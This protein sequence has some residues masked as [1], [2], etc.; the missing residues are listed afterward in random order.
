VP[1]QGHPKEQ[2]A[3]YLRARL[4]P[5]SLLRDFDGDVYAGRPYVVLIGIKDGPSEDEAM[6]EVHGPAFRAEIEADPEIAPM[7]DRVRALGFEVEW[8]SYSDATT[9]EVML[10]IRRNP[11]AEARL[12]KSVPDAEA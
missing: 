7:L 2:R 6:R 4:E 12:R 10:R 5:E 1:P 11:E 9:T 3:A 8:G